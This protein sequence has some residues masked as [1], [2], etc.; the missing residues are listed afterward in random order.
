MSQQDQ[1]STL[2]ETALALVVPGTNL[3]PREVHC[4]KS[5]HQPQQCW[6]QTEPPC[7]GHEAPAQ[8]LRLAAG[9]APF[10]PLKGMSW[11]SALAW[12]KDANCHPDR[13]R[14]GGGLVARP[15][16]SPTRPL[17]TH[18]SQTCFPCAF[19]GNATVSLHTALS[20]SV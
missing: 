12:P 6:A 10:M 13:A 16:E 20:P 3:G 18:S 5:Q 14:Q 15:R 9:R 7:A 4:N 1:D 17:E 2:V 11:H 8:S 19:R